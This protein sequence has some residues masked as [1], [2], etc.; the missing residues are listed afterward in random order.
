MSEPQEGHTANL[1]DKVV[2][3]ASWN[4]VGRIGTQFVQT[5]FSIV[6]ARLLTPNEF[7]A[8]GMLAVFTGF[9][10]VLADSGLGA[11]LIYKQDITEAHRSTVFWLQVAISIP[12]TASFYFSAPAIAGFYNLSVLGPLTRLVSFVFLIQAI[13]QTQRVLL[14]KEFKFR[15]IAIVSLGTTIVSGVVA[16]VMA[17]CGFGVWALA[18][19]MVLSVALSSIFFMFISGW[20]PRFQFERAAATEMVRYGIYVLGYASLNYWQ[21]NGDNL[22]I[23]KL[24]GAHA[25]GIYA[26]AYSL[27]LLPI[28]NI[29]RALGQVMFPALSRLQD[30]ISR[31]GRSYI[32]ATQMI[33]LVAFPLMTG[34]GILSGP[35][36]RVVFGRKWL[37]MIPI[38]TI[39][40]FVG[41]AQAVIVSAGWVYNALGRT[42]TAFQIAMVMG[43]LFV[44]AILGGIQYGLL[45]VVYAYAAWTVLGGVVHLHVAGR[46]M[47]LSMWTILRNIAK[48]SLMSLA[49]G[50]VVLVFDIC[51]R[52]I[53]PNSLR[54]V[55]GTLLGALVYLAE[56][57]LT[58]DSTFILLLEVM[59]GKKKRLA[60]TLA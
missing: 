24:L 35:F 16:V 33:A 25:L 17:R 4:L 19:Q 58:R 8:I 38:L 7:G 5:G 11:A 22:A 40:S 14:S 55:V 46:F 43:I 48:I 3:S 9:A 56:C 30:D 52:H 53:W 23:G 10:Q 27:M 37:E 31:F 13:G 18:W 60:N 51:I 57:I 50:I 54:L 12:L 44:V 2:H 20:M 32:K 47:H 42:K 28:T 49:M 34:L 59:G 41:L 36:I 21:R 1:R 39:F 6:L 45:G 26:R 29:T 15:K